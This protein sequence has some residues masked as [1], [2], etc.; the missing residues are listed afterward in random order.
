MEKTHPETK[1]SKMR[2]KRGLTVMDVARSLGISHTAVNKWDKGQGYPK[3]GRLA[4][5]AKVLKC[6]PGDLI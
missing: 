5:V 2:E 4:E 3:T 1:F 6:K